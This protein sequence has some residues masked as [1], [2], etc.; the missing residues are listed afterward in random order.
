MRAAFVLSF[1]AA[2]APARAQADDTFEAKAAGAQRIRKLENLVWPLTAACDLGDDTTRRQCRRVRDARAA[3]LASATII[4]DAEPAAFAIAPWSAQKKSSAVSLSACL[5]CTGLDIDGKTWFVVGNKDGNPPP[6][7]E[8]GKLKVGLLHDNARPFADDAAAKAFAKG[9][10]NARVQLIV[11]VAAKAKTV[12]DGKN[13]LAFDVLGYRVYQPCDGGIVCASPRSGP[14]EADKKSCGGVATSEGGDGARLEQ[15]TAPVISHA[16][17]PVVEAA[18][19]CFKKYG[20]AGKGKLKMT[21]AGDGSVTSY[22]QQGDFANTPTG[23]CI[24]VAAKQASFPKSKRE[25]TP[26]SFPIK[27]Q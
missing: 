13:V 24:D 22:E 18:N 8:G 14:A 16:M 6:R 23:K 25:R 12:V 7:F 26:I 20:I 19:E 10:A 15:L 2:A 1:L 4:V 17:R 9:A 5:G 3:E 21:V 27:L 11:K